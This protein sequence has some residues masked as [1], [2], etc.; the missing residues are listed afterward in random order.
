[1]DSS[2]SRCLWAVCLA[3]MVCAKL[4][5]AER[6]T[7]NDGN[8]V[9]V[10]IL[11]INGERVVLTNATPAAVALGDLWRI[12]VTPPSSAVSGLVER[13]ILERG[14]IPARRLT[15]LDGLCRFDWTGGNDAG[16]T[17]TLVRALI[18]KSGAEDATREA[19]ECALEK[20]I[21]ADQVVALGPNDAVLTLEGS[22][23]NVGTNAIVL[24]YQGKD[25]TLNRGKV[26]AVVF[27]RTGTMD[28]AAGALT[29]KATVAGGAWLE[30]DKARLADGTLT[31]TIGASTMVIPWNKVCSLEHRDRKVRFLSRMDPVQATGGA[32]VA[33]ALPWQRDR[34]AMSR[35]LRLRGEI[36]E[37][38][39]GTHAPSELVFDVPEGTQ[40]FM[41]MV[42]L[43]E[44]FGRGGDCV[45][46][47]LV[48]D[49]EVLRQRL[50]GID[51]PLPVDIEIRN[52]RRLT[53]RAEPGENHDIGDHV[54]WYDARLLLA[55]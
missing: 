43:D 21:P 16:V 4:S 2:T 1:M 49:R 47:V 12:E 19:T 18:L 45:V 39:L 17:Q 29:W 28:R 54:N 27:G 50:R 7:R 42:G 37:T 20:T 46:V 26:G 52:A 35:P 10:N 22:V 51:K 5:A 31:L 25:R 9:D 14:E 32:I 8:T 48:D 33:L 6:L 3:L 40:R 23:K 38:G 30:G 44:E 24:E 11:A 13:I 53:L 36:H 41:A 15:L 55:P 34:N